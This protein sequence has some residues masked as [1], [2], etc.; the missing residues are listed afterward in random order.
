LEY[1]LGVLVNF[2]SGFGE[3]DTVMGTIEQPG[4]EMFFQLAHLEGYRRLG[5]VKG[6]GGFGEAQQAGNGIKYM[7][8]SISHGLDLRKLN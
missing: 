4:I 2:L 8:S 6:F 5:H 1:S 7:Q 3:T